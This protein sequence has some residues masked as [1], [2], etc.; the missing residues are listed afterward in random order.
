MKKFYVQAIFFLILLN[1]CSL[2]AETTVEVRA[3]AFFPA[4]KLFR[5]IYGNTAASYGVEASTNFNNCC[6]CLNCWDVWANFDW[7][8]KHGE[9]ANCNSRHTRVKIA[10]FSCGIKFP[11]HL[12]E[13]DSFVPYAG[14]GPSFTRIWLK[15]KTQCSKEN[16]SKFAFGGI[17]KFGINYYF[18]NCMFL[19]VFVDYLY[20]PVHFHHE[21]NIGGFKTGAGI[22]MRF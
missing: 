5:K 14:I 4:S 9:S 15:N 8:S 19:D 12:F 7:F 20:Q 3:D 22:G 6:E 18:S 21:V 11:F 10:N 1:F 2:T 16:H 13:C 17:A